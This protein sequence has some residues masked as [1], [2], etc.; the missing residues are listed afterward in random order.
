MQF[1]QLLRFALGGL[2]RQKVRTG[3]TLIGVSIGACALAFSVALGTGLRAFIDNEFQSRDEFWRIRVHAGEPSTEADIPP[4]RIAVHGVMSEERKSRIREALVKKYLEETIRKPP[5]LLTAATL[6]AIT[7]LP[8][9]REVRTTRSSGGRVWLGEHSA[10]GMVVAGNLSSLGDRLVAGHLPETGDAREAVVSEFTLYE[11][12]IDSDSGFEAALGRTVSIDV[13]VVRNAQPMALARALTGRFPGD[14]LS[15]SQAFALHRLTEQLPGSLDKFDLSPAERAALK[16]LLDKKPDSNEQR[17]PDSGKFVSGEFHLVGIVRYPTKEERKKTDPLSP[18]EFRDGTVFLP[19]G[20]GEDLFRQLPWLN[21]QGFYQAEVWVKP[22]GDMPGTVNEI[23][24][25]GFQTMSA[26]KWFASAKKEVTLIAG[27][28][29]LFAFIALFVAGIGITN[30]LVTSVV[31]RTREIGILKAVG[32]T[33]G[34][35]LGIFLT[36]GAAIGLLGSTLGLVLARLLVIPADGWVH[37]MIEGQMMG[38]KMLTETIF[39]FPWWLWAGAMG[40]AV[41]V[42]TAAAYYPALRAARIDP[43]LALRYE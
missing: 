16:T 33:R 11:L 30:T 12:G 26:L 13:G 20:S 31:E 5:V 22:G 3:L 37:R 19:S 36:E 27:G 4:E 38:Q 1:H 29:N 41:V 15:R 34:Q 39:V 9:V 24:A 18:W 10:P 7:R 28:L 23:E 14:D 42:T 21:V 25:M 43:I 32:A 8:E 6:A 40:F 17:R 2:W 35:I